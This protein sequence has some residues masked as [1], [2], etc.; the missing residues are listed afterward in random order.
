MLRYILFV[1]VTCLTS[2][3]HAR[4]MVVIQSTLPGVFSAGQILSSQNPLIV[5]KDS[6]ITLVFDTGDTLTVRGFYEGKVKK[7]ESDQVLANPELV[8]TLASLIRGEY[9]SPVKTVMRANSE[10]IPQNIWQV[11]LSTNKRHYCVKAPDSVMLWRPKN[12][13]RSA[14][15]LLIKHKMTGKNSQLMWPA[16]QS[17]LA[18]PN[19]LPIIYGD[20]YTVELE[21]LHGG[22]SFKKLVLY[23]LPQDLPTTSHKIV[24][25]A[26]KGCI[27]QANRLLASLR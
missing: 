9:E 21:N 4:D 11:D 18:W 3:V 10:E 15:R 1:I 23:Q 19:D 13:S 24:W 8:S 26:G 6:E 17:T 22:S 7:P 25:M 16:H 12:E 27:P 20:T 2:I 14:S 5:P